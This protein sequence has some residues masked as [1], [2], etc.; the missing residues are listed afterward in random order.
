M[1]AGLVL[2]VVSMSLSCDPDGGA[3]G[4]DGATPPPGSADAATP[5]AADAATPVGDDVP[6]CAPGSRF[7]PVPADT[8]APGPWPVG[9]RTVSV[10]RLTVEVFYPARPGSEAG[11]PAVRYDIRQQ[12]PASERAKIPDAENPWQPCD[13]V[14]DL[15]LDDAHGPYPLV[16]FI[17]GTAGFRTQSLVAATHWA[18]RGFVVVA[19]DHP[20]L[21]LGDLLALACFQPQ[22]GARTI[23]ADVDAELAAVSAGAGELAFLSGKLDL[24]RIAVVGHSAGASEA[25]ALSGRAGVRVIVAL[26]GNAAVAASP[27][28][29]ANLWMAAKSDTVVSYASSRSGY[30]GSPSPRHFVGV[31][32]SGHLC[33]SD[34]CGLKNAAGMDLLQIANAHGVCGA[35]L[36]GG[37]FDCKPSYLPVAAGMK[38]VDD[39]TSA[40]LEGTLRCTGAADTL[41]TI[42]TR[43]PGEVFEA[44]SA[45]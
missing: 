20:G 21:F 19:A 39:A 13:C 6:G 45:P 44:L 24:D 11:L 18:S 43:Y 3:A 14:R 29:A 40:V 16:V 31:A 33:F 38:I 23:A 1:F 41:A 7:L 35:G 10:G 32:N 25:A 27:T 5:S 15:P 8:S 4:P 2:S 28:L 12:L 30:D 17:H 36:A 22:S 37:L 42:A 34:L 26:A 9:A